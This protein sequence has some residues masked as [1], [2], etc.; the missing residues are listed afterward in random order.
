MSNLKDSRRV[1]V[2]GIGVLASNGNNKDQF[3][4]N[5]VNGVTGIK[6]CTLFYLKTQ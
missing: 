5:C 4:E 3:Y 2:T 1:V 6:E